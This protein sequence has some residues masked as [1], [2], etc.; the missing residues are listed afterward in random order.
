MSVGDHIRLAL[1]H[2]QGEATKDVVRSAF[3]SGNLTRDSPDTLLVFEL[4][5]LPGSIIR[6]RAVA[7]VPTTDIP[8][9][10]GEP[11]HWLVKHERRGCYVTKPGP[12]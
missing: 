11:G 12:S 3:D 7:D 6:Y 8:C 5:C 9:P 1:F 4:D 2:R 10:C